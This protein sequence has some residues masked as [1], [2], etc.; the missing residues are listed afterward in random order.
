MILNFQANVRT[1]PEISSIFGFTDK[2]LQILFKW[3]LNFPAV[4]LRGAIW[5]PKFISISAAVAGLEKNP[6]G[7]IFQDFKIPKN[8]NNR[9]KVSGKAARCSIVAF[10]LV[11]CW[12]Y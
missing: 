6:R 4:V 8:K 1:I 9:S 7:F 2:L 11:M 3:H 12:I 5:W 10:R